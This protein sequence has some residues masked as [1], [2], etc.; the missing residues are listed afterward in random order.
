MNLALCFKHALDK[1]N[2]HDVECWDVTFIRQY[3]EGVDNFEHRLPSD[4]K[5]LENSRFKYMVTAKV[6]GIKPDMRITMKPICALARAGGISSE[7]TQA[8]APR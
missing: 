6:Q 8:D 4:A 5:L 2:G 7:A 1:C 3:L